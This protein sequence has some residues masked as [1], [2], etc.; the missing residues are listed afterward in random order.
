MKI[1]LHTHTKKCK[2]GDAPT[3]NVSPSDF[4]KILGATEVGII[5][6]TN[7]NCFDLLQF[8]EI[9][10]GSNSSLQVWPGIELDVVEGG[11]RGHLLVITSPSKANEFSTAVDNI[12]D[13]STPDDFETTI[14]EVLKEFDQLE[15][16]YVAH[17]EQKKPNIPDD[18]IDELIDGT[19]NPGRVIKEVTNSISAGIYISHGHSSIYGSDVQDWGSYEINSRNLPDL[20]LPVESFEHFC[21]LL[22]KDPTTINTALDKKDTEQL[23]LSPF[24]DDS[25]L[26][27]RAYNDINIIFGPKGTG[28]SCILR[29]IAKHYSEKGIEATVYE[30]ASDKL[31][32]IF[33]IK[34]RDLSL[35]LQSFG[36]NYCKDEIERLRE[37]AEVDVTGISKYLNYFRSRTTNKNAKKIKIKNIDPEEEGRPRRQFNDFNDAAKKVL[38]FLDFL[39]ED[40]AVEKVLSEDELTDLQR[41][42]DDLFNRLVDKEWKSFSRW[43]EICLLNSAIEKFRT[44]VERKTGT[45]AKPITTG[46]R[47]YALNRLHIVSDATEILRSVEMKIPIEKEFI[48]NLGTSK[49]GLELRTEYKIQ[50]GNIGDP[51]LSKLRGVKKVTQQKFCKKVRKILKHAYKSDLFVHVAELNDIPD[52]EQ[53]E[54]VYE[55]MLFKRYFALEGV[56]YTPS[57]GE[58]SMVMLQKELET[59]KDIYILDE[60][61]RSLGNEYIS[62][63]IVPLINDRARAGK[64]VF[65]STHDANIAVRT[66]PYSSVYRC[67]GK[68]GYATYIGNPFSNNLVNLSDKVDVMDW[69]N[70]SMR[71]LEGGE[72]AFGDRGRIYGNN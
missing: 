50:D 25:I 31:D 40:P 30:S 55:L 61:E 47:E 64:K 11:V 52:I 10:H 27:I 69:K 53:I 2:S 6:I 70:V 62:E 46:F 20:R 51:K 37:S 5:A 13:G 3:R 7:H 34:G 21:L 4:K 36:I 1:D 43:K 41:V 49:G 42:V 72:R 35:N 39:G 67:H 28:K 17:Y 65:I 33:D 26:D 44:E 38:E 32:E 15:P 23:S 18:L 16:L 29:A 71:T 60:P 59:N 45:P 14:E 54:T 8:N 63:V 48:G 22:E 19:A 12:C 58:A 56:Q 66:L 9:E 24:E 68:D 57:S